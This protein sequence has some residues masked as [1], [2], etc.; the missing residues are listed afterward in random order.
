[1]VTLVKTFLKLLDVVS[2]FLPTLAH[3]MGVRSNMQMWPKI[4]G[5]R[6]G[7]VRYGFFA[8]HGL[9]ER[10]EEPNTICVRVT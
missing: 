5:V 10:D 1:M 4:P 3:T 2:A 7:P 8:T 6:L 9:F